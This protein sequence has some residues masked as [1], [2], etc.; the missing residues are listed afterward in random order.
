MRAQIMLVLSSVCLCAYPS[1]AGADMTFVHPGAL[2]TEARLEFV[3]AR[4]LAGE[5]PWVGEFE[6][7]LGSAS[8]SRKPHVLIRISS[9][10]DAS[11]ARDDALAAYTQ[12]LLWVFTGE[13]VYA[14]R[15]VA[16]LEAWSTFQGFTEGSDED[17]LRAGW[18]GSVFAEAAE[19]MR[20]RGGLN[21]VQIAGLKSMFRRS[22]YP[23]LKT[24]STWNG[25]VDLTQIEALLAIAVF[26]EDQTEFKLGLARLVQRNP[27]YFYLRNDAQE[28]RAI[29]GDGGNAERFWFNPVTWVD[30]LTQETCRDGG[31]HSQ[32]GLG[33]ALNAAEIAWNQGI[34]VYTANTLRYTSA[35]E[36]LASQLLAGNVS[37]C[38]DRVATGSRY[39]TWEVG[40]NHYHNRQG[41]DLPN[42]KKLIVEQIRTRSERAS[43]N[44]VYETL[45]HAGFPDNP[46]EIK[47]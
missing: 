30:G 16:I 2:N 34:D 12:A 29:A 17:K 10:R 19:I 46:G 15:S 4:I 47:P 35:M 24:A 42:T 8:S 36:L 1:V 11:T 20:S 41:L 5:Q 27:A 21:D 40:Y 7:I 22:F 31:H 33:S 45:T 44:L 18:L 26:N 3:K 43:W 38:A 9:D 13:E 23:H 6:N 14:R 32:F 39:N 37:T 25:N 28:T